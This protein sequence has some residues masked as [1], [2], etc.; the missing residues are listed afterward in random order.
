MTVQEEK[1]PSNIKKIIVGIVIGIIIIGTIVA[2]I[3]L[4]ISQSTHASNAPT[5]SLLSVNSTLIGTK[6]EFSAYVTTKK[7]DL[8]KYIFSFDNG[9]SKYVNCTAVSFP[10]GKTAAWV[11]VTS[12]R[13]NATST[14]TCHWKI[15]ANNTVGIVSSS[16]IQSFT[17]SPYVEVDYKTIGWFYG[18]INYNYT[19]LVLT[20]TITNHC[21]TSGVK[22]NGMWGFYVKIGNNV[23]N[24]TLTSGGTMYNATNT[25]TGYYY[26]DSSPAMTLLNTG[27]INATVVFQFGN[28]N[29]VPS[30]PQIWNQPFTLTYSDT[31]NM[32]FGWAISPSST[33]VKIF[34][35]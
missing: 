3:A 14:V 16:G 7:G 32:F 31:N 22:V 28:P 26:T 6:P 19:Y 5:F 18:G 1:K 12:C 25:F 8:S 4:Q 34:Q 10:T 13:L 27:A 15:Y 33:T 24:T 17:I 35:R 11:N 23:Y 21:Y 2:G 30:P 20:L 29:V 9:T